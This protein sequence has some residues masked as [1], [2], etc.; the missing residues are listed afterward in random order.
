MICVREN[1]TYNKAGAH[2]SLIF[3]YT[4]IRKVFQKQQP[5]KKVEPKLIYN[6]ICIRR[7][8]Y[9][10]LGQIIIA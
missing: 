6:F 7:H 9:N 4:F 1:A 2:K 8:L 10:F 3:I 5:L